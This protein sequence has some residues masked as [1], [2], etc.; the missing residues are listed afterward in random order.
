VDEQRVPLQHL[1]RF[2][3]SSIRGRCYDHNFLRKN[4][5]FS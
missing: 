5:R 4:W 1:K 3:Q 2:K